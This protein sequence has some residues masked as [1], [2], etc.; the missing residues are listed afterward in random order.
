M[1]LMRT[2][3]VRAAQ[4]GFE[5]SE[6]LL[7]RVEIGAAGRQGE[8]TGAGVFDGHSD[9]CDLMARQIVQ[10]HDIAG[11]ELGN[12]EL[13]DPG[14]E[15]LAVHWP[16]EGAR[17]DETVMP[18]RADEGGR[19]PM[20]PRNRRNETLAARASAGEPGHFGRGAGFVDKD[21]VVCSPFGLLR[22]PSPA[23]FRNV[24]AV[25]LCGALRLFLSVSPR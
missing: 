4:Q 7:D 25:L 17:R 12:Q 10:H 11:L 9:A 3:K 6:P 18:Q 8:Q 22:P 15:R 2:S 16:V 5:F 21:Q 19:L 24:G 23:R 14:A 1:A 20:T 13:L